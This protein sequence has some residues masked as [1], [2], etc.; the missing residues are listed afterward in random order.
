MNNESPDAAGVG[1]LE[2]TSRL[3]STCCLLEAKSFSGITFS[4]ESKTD[5]EL[6]VFP[7]HQKHS[8][9]TVLSFFAFFLAA[10]AVG[11]AA[12]ALKEAYKD[13]ENGGGSLTNDA[14]VTDAPKTLPV[15]RLSNDAVAQQ[16]MT[17][18]VIATDRTIS[19]IAFG[20]CTT[21]F[22]SPQ[23]I[24]TK[25]RPR[26]LHRLLLT[27]ID[28]IRASSRLHQTHGSGW[29]TSSTWTMHS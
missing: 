29:A 2:L 13:N 21:Y 19:K 25:V 5:P 4:G 24:W 15:D 22:P 3:S 14:G 6:A 12:A 28:P 10:I 20:S 23:P 9:S 17:R 26:I 16:M 18:N 7:R 11:L 8:L 27:A 1:M